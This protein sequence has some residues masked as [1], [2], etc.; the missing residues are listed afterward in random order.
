MSANVSLCCHVPPHVRKADASRQVLIRVTYL[1]KYG[2]I[3]TPYR[4]GAEPFNKKGDLKDGHVNTEVG[5]LIIT[6]RDH[7]NLL[8]TN[9]SQ[10]ETAIQL[11]D[12]LDAALKGKLSVT[13]TS[14]DDEMNLIAFW[15]KQCDDS[16]IEKG[17]KKNIRASLKSFKGYIG[18][19]NFDV[20]ELYSG[21][22]SLFEIWIKENVKGRDGGSISDATVYS[23]L[24]YLRLVFNNMRKSLNNYNTNEIKVS[25]EPFKDYKMPKSV[26]KENSAIPIETI[27]E[28]IRYEPTLVRAKLARDAFM[29]SF[30]LFGI[31]TVDLYEATISLGRLD[32]YRRKTRKK[33][34][35]NA[36]MSVK[37]EPELL[38]YMDLNRDNSE[39]RAFNFYNRYCDFDT[40]NSAVNKGFKILRKDLKITVPNFTFYSARKSFAT[41]MFDLGIQ[42]HIISDCLNHVGSSDTLL[43]RTV[44]R[45]NNKHKLDPYNR[46]LID[47]LFEKGEFE[48]KEETDKTKTQE[49]EFEFLEE[50]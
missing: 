1:R 30:M 36:S 9:I 41:I 34:E 25:N 18:K 37:I 47:F 31:N 45:K 17:T 49:F 3:K 39:K 26:I 10:F 50:A 48:K 29:L 13:V 32:Y 42:D 40:F 14:N 33:R 12:H 7:V 6:L 19:D 20:R 4:V 46:M 43:A 5:R 8:G 23:Y 2:Y 15:E 35:D 21:H 24:T 27:R 44:Y 38:P 16:T 28:I 22:L 11:A